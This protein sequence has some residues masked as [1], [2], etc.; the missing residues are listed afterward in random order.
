MNREELAKKAKVIIWIPDADG[1]GERT[2]YRF[3]PPKGAPR[4]YLCIGRT[5]R[6]RR[7]NPVFVGMYVSMA[8]LTPGGKI[9]VEEGEDQK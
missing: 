7:F 3:D 5:A 8:K 9:H 4:Y 6:P 1:E 2:M